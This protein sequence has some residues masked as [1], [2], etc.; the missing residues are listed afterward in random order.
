MQWP[1]RR[2]GKKKEPKASKSVDALKQLY[3][4]YQRQ[5]QMWALVILSAVA[6]ACLFFV[7]SVFTPIDLYILLTPL[8]VVVFAGIQLRKCRSLVGILRHALMIQQEIDKADS[9]KKA[10]EE[11]AELELQARIAEE[12][13]Q[14]KADRRRDVLLAD[15][16]GEPKPSVGPGSPNPD[17]EG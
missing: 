2:R 3:R 10:D 5:S 12:E 9:K 15:P 8:A 6:V 1:W 17:S 16:A 7:F 11:A 14:A 13:A 4:N